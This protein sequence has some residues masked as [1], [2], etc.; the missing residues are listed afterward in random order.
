MKHLRNGPW[1][2]GELPEWDPY[3]VWRERVRLAPEAPNRR[4]ASRDNTGAGQP[5]A[6]RAEPGDAAPD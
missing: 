6:D 1:L 5:A 2:E 4:E 3:K